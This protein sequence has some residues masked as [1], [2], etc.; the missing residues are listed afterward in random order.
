MTAAGDRPLLLAYDGS[1]DARRAIEA[2]VALLGARRAL[3]VHVYQPFVELLTGGDLELPKAI[4]A[5]AAE[6]ARLDREEAEA[7][8][9]EGVEVARA[10]GLEAAGL[11][12]KGS[13]SVWP[14]ILEVADEHD[15]CA[16]VTGSRG[17]SGVSRV[18]GSV[19]T[20]VVHHC[21]RPVL[22]VPPA[23]D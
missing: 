19:S 2:A 21:E 12:V 4:A 8:A 18:L 7:T 14:T 6:G 3:V 13:M 11:V 17:R 22:V 23:T 10:A 15:V 20:G 1:G 9:T 5:E 16:V